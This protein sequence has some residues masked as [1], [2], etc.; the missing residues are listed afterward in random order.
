[1]YKF[2]TLVTALTLSCM[3]TFATANSGP[4]SRSQLLNTVTGMSFHY[5]GVISGQR[6]SGTMSYHANQNLQVATDS[7]APEGGTWFVDKN[8]LCTKLVTLRDGRTNCFYVYPKG[9]GTYATSH[10]FTLIPM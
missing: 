6:F 3:T 9:N 8:Q 1:M 5:V 4:L 7:G 2:I 10:G